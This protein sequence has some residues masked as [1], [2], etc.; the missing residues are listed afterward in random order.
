MKDGA[1]S[2]LPKVG[3]VAGHA[4]FEGRPDRKAGESP[5]FDSLYFYGAKDGARTRNPQLGKLMPYH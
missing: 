3:L 5:D 4:F 1:R 2:D